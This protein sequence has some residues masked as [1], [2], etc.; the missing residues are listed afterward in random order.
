MKTHSILLIEDDQA[1][2]EILSHRLTQEG[3]K[4]EWIHDGFQGYQS[5]I[6]NRPELLITDISLPSL[7]GIEIITQ[8]NKDLS[9]A[10]IPVII[11]SNSFIPKDDRQM[12]ELG[13]KAFLVKALLTPTEIINTIDTIMDTNN[14]NDQVQAPISSGIPRPEILGEAID[15]KGKQILLVEDDAFLHSI[16]AKRFEGEGATVIHAVTGE[17]AIAAVKSS[18]IDLAVLDVLL[19]GMNGFEVLKVIRNNEATSNI[20]VVVVSNFSQPEDIEKAK[21]CGAHYL[22]KALVSPD[23]IVS[24]IREVLAGQLA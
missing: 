3:H 6:H 10:G 24:K 5:L 16:L 9:I 13:V 1:L 19:P 11:L 8:K 20:P 18:R 7:S 2:G 4:V 23:E 17:E 14:T 21:E 15:L 12:N 22:V